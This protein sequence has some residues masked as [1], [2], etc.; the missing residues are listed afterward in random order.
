MAR[1]VIRGRATGMPVKRQK[2]HKPM[3]GALAPNAPKGYGVATSP[4]S[5]TSAK[6]AEERHSGHRMLA[7]GRR[8]KKASGLITSRHAFPVTN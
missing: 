1:R 2:W 7:A 8:A 6:A 5:G 3:K 4:R